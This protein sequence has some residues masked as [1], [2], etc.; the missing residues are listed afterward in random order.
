MKRIVDAWTRLV[1][2]I[3]TT[4]NDFKDAMSNPFLA[5]LLGSLGTTLLI[6]VTV[7]LFYR[8]TH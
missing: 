4:R 3:E 1:G 2:E 8:L 6:V 7:V 5:I